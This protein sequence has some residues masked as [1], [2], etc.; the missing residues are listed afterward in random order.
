MD[1]EELMVHNTGTFVVVGHCR[2]DERDQP[3]PA[4][5]M[6]GPQ[7]RE[8]LRGLAETFMRCLPPSLYIVVDLVNLTRCYKRLVRMHIAITFMPCM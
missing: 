4:M 5:D 3:K 8:A 1:V 7:L 2:A 6:T